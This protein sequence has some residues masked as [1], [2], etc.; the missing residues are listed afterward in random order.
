MTAADARRRPPGGSGH[1]TLG[2][3]LCC[4]HGL[5]KPVVHAVLTHAA[6]SPLAP[7]PFEGLLLRYADFFAADTAF[8][9]TDHPC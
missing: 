5:P 7:E 8:F 2:G 4:E 3:M 6:A 9:D 1:A